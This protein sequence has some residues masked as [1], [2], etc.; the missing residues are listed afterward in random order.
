MAKTKASFEEQIAE[1]HVA[2][3]ILNL[4]KPYSAVD[5]AEA[6]NKNIKLAKG[7]QQDSEYLYQIKVLLCLVPTT[8]ID[9]L[10]KNLKRKKWIDWFVENSMKHKRLDL[11]NQV[12][13]NPK[14]AKY[15]RREVRK[16]V[17][18]VFG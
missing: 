4:L 17:N 1:E 10:A 14:G 18:L 13:Y 9:K 15:I 11:Y 7:L 5:M 16:I 3:M 12:V 8:V 2:P 6:I